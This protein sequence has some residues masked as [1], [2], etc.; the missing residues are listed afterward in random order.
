MLLVAGAVLSM[1]SPAKRGVGD[2]PFVAR[3]A[4]PPPR[5]NRPPA[6]RSPQVQHKLPYPA[7]PAPAGV[8]GRQ[9]LLTI[10]DRTPGV[11]LRGVDVTRI[12]TSQLPGGKHFW[13]RPPSRSSAIFGGWYLRRFH[14]GDPCLRRAGLQ[15]G[16]IIAEVNGSSLS[17]PSDL[18]KLWQS[19]RTAQRIVV[20]LYRRGQPLVF[21]VKIAGSG[22]RQPPRRSPN[23]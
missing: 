1:A 19:L 9:Q 15:T 3:S 20:R 4:Q 7:C 10:L 18:V 22:P 8:I 14:P 13:K 11:F 12:P 6:R 23:G 5:G 2:D 17:H 21:V 16:D